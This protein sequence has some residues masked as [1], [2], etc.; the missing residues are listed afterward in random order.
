MKKIAV[1][2]IIAILFFA[3]GIFISIA[4]EKPNQQAGYILEHEK[5]IAKDEPG[6]HNGGGKSTAY[7]FFS[8]DSASKLVFRKRVCIQALPLVIISSSKKKFIT[9]KAA[10]AK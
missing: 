5:D 9:L 1:T 7:N 8:S 4:F 6:P 3:A 2:S 10:Q